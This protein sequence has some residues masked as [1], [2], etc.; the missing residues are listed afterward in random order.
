VINIPRARNKNNIF[1]KK[2][3]K[4][5]KEKKIMINKLNVK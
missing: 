2:N 4:K 1:S 5:E 3:V